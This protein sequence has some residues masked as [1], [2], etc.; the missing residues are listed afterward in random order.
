MFRINFIEMIC[1]GVIF[2][3]VFVYFCKTFIKNFFV[4]IC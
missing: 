3:K 4:F 1:N 2:H